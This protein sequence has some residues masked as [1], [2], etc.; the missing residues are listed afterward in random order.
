[1]AS[2]VGAGPDEADHAGADGTALWANQTEQR[3]AFLTEAGDVLAASLDYQDTLRRVARLAVPRI[4]DWC[5]VD[6]AGDDGALHRLAVV[7]AD[8]A[9]RTAAERLR[10]RYPVIPP[11]SAHTAAR[12]VREGRAWADPAVAPARLA[13]EAR[14]PEHLA[15]L[16]E[17]GFGAELVAPLVARGHALGTITLVSATP[18]RYGDPADRQ[19]VEALARRCALAVDNARLYREAQASRDRAERLQ[20]I[21]VQL[22]QRL[23][24]DAVLR[25]VVD[26]AAE[27]LESQFAG[28]YLLSREDRPWGRG[29]DSG[30]GDTFILAAARGLDE[31]REAYRHLPR[32]GSLGGRALELGR[33]LGIDDVAGAGQTAVLPALATGQAVGALLVAPILAPPVGILGSVDDARNPG[34]AGREEREALGVIEVYATAPRPWKRDDERLLTA[35]ASAAGVAVANARLYRSAQEEASIQ[36]TLNTALRE[37]AEARDA[38]LAEAEAARERLAFL[39]EAS[40][41]LATS[42]DYEA[43]LATVARLAVPRFADWCAVDM[44]AD[45]GTIRRLASAHVDPSK[46]ELAREISRRYPPDPDAPRGLHAVLRSGQPELYREISDEVLVAAARDHQH[47]ELLRAAG[48]V[49]AIVAPL[50]ARGR[51]LGTLTLAWAESGRRYDGAD[52]D[53]AGEIARR[54]ALA[55]DNARLYGD[56][57]ASRQR[58]EALAAEREQFLAA[59]SHDLKNPLAAA[60][61]NAQMLQRTLARTGTVPPERLTGA[62]ANISTS[63]E[64]MTRQINELLDMARARLG[65][66]L[67]LERAPT[68]L[69][70]LARQGVALQQAATDRHRLRVEATVPELVG[71]WDTVRLERVLGNLLSNAVKYSPDGGEVVV[72]VAREHGLQGRA[73]ETGETGETKGSDWAVLGVRD[74]GVGIPAA[75]LERIFEQFERGANVTGRIEGTGIGLTAARQVVEQ[76]GGTISVESAEGSGTTVTVR[77]PVAAPPLPSAAGGGATG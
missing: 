26:A 36:A 61:G 66:P 71:E 65:Q 60:W 40:A 27:L 50:A 3:L 9:K 1:L 68:D 37:T 30:L 69:V 72:T 55:V 13:A 52:L 6:V 73:G 12:V 39:A 25:Q 47:L 70:A 33:T 35:L 21:T 28:V 20:A 14:D 18:G 2:V 57:Q 62:L 64:R 49:S 42:L 15:L 5:A 76:H 53:T 48:L 34:L 16:C 11:G 59:A 67:S 44:V 43:T 46:A 32:R 45:D 74:E 77:L 29:S 8:P 19:L 17:L 58:V 23:D 51:V 22:G 31:S 10:E 41:Q 56:A 38:A 63:L 7:H 75:D 54:A 4:A 24:A